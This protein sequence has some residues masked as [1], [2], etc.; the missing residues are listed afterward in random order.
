MLFLVI[1]AALAAQQAPPSSDLARLVAA[2][3]A[4]AAATRELGVRDGFLTFFHD[5]AIDV[6]PVEGRLALVR[7]KARLRA[8]PPAA[9]P[10]VRVLW[11]DPRWGAISRDGTLGWLTGPFRMH[12]TTGAAQVRYGAY[13]SIWRRQPD[14]TYKVIL[15]IGIDTARAVTFPDVFTAASTPPAGVIG[16]ARYAPPVGEA[17]IRLQEARF[18]EAA[19]KDLGA[20]YRAHLA[21]DARLHRNERSP[22]VGAEAAAGFMSSTFDRIAWAVL[23]AEMADSGDLAF[24]VGSYDAAAKSSE[25]RP[26]TPERGFFVRVW[27]RSGDSWKI[28]FETNGIR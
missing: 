2:E 5:D 13:F 19:S 20:A 1:A 26:G 18:A 21:P 17:E 27:H 6:A 23:H 28:A 22:F 3:R 10:P 12:D 4:F 9:V 15:D 16:D 25:G 14:H 7:M 11:W 24:T 8:Q